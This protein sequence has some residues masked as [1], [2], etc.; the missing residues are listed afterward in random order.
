MIDNPLIAVGFVRDEHIN[1]VVVVKIGLCGGD[2]DPLV[3]GLLHL[4]FRPLP[5][6][7]RDL[8]CVDSAKSDPLPEEG[9]D[10]GM[11]V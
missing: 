8:R 2:R 11:D 1:E 3:L 6:S 9:T 4:R 5:F 7:G 10:R